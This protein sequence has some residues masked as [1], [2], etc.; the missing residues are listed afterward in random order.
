MSWSTRGF[1]ATV[2]LCALFT[3]LHAD[4]SSSGDEAPPPEPALSEDPRLTEDPRKLAFEQY[5]E[6]DGI[7]F[8]ELS[9]DDQAIATGMAEAVDTHQGHEVSQAWSRAARSARQRAQVQ[10]AENAAGIRDAD[11]LGVR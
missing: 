7:P 5:P 10:R 4:S 2:A 3:A 8:E 9:A 6:P 11:V 1:L